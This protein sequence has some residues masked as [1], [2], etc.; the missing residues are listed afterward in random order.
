MPRQTFDSM[1]LMNLLEYLATHSEGHPSRAVFSAK[2]AV[3]ASE[4]T[5]DVLEQVYQILHVDAESLS[6][7]CNTVGVNGVVSLFDMPFQVETIEWKAYGNQV[8]I[9]CLKREVH[10]ITDSISFLEI[11][12]H[13]MVGQGVRKFTADLNIH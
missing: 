6:I 13:K 4:H 12:R 2:L 9:D 3:H 11:S 5:H 10:V 8:R 7:R 1:N